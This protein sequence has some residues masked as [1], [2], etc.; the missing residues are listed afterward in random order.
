MTAAV[1][2]PGLDRGSRGTW[3][4]RV[5]ASVVGRLGRHDRGGGSARAPGSE[6]TDGEGGHTRRSFLVRIAIFASAL[7]IGPL[8]FVLRPGT[9]YAAVCG[10]GAGCDSGWTAFCCTINDGKN[11]CP[12]DSFAAGW[13]KN[14][15]SSFCGGGPRYIID[16]NA[17]C[18]TKCGCRC[19]GSS[20]C[21][22]RKTCCNQFRYGQC[23]QEIACAGPVVCRVA[24][25]AAPWDFDPS[26][27]HGSATDNATSEHGAPCITGIADPTTDVFAFDVPALG[28][29]A[30]QPLTRP[31][32]GMAA[33][34]IG[35]G[36]WLVASDGGIFAY[37]ASRFWGSTGAIALNKPIVGMASTRTGKGY[38]LVA[39]DGGI[40]AYGDAGFYGSTGAIKLNKPVVGMAETPSGLGYWL[41]ASDGG[42]F[43][44]GDARFWGS[45]GGMTLN[46]PIVGMASTPT[47]RGY[48]LVAS[49]G[50]IFA[51]G[52]A[53]FLGSMGATPLVRP[54]V[55]IAA[56][57]SGR[58]YWL[59]AADGGVFAFGDASFHGSVDRA[60]LGSGAAVG[61]APAPPVAVPPTTTTGFSVSSTTTARAAGPN[62]GYWIVVRRRA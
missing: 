14:D 39:S 41:V 22:Q 20:T 56:T 7:S 38:W 11:M 5:V 2:L 51:F 28:S 21:D 35:E 33:H 42:I 34:P 46:K 60:A 25:C 47:G 1:A 31:M 45:T 43:A 4:E 13:W 54:V 49:D 48:W 44:Y 59:V 30:G 36:Y 10:P 19:S 16:C 27:G 37:G 57:A 9:A 6:A 12:P 23:H 62:P 32:V 50:G 15:T 24:T 3:P 55:A 58:G 29:P 26:C 8:R 40:F 17:T 61:L 18:P 53:P 52:D